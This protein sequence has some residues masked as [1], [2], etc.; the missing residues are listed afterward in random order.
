MNKIYLVLSNGLEPVAYSNVKKV[1]ESLAKPDFKYHQ[2][3]DGLRNDGV[4]RLA[5]GVVVK[6]VAIS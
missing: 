3:C 1:F 4:F 6:K 5:T 2:L